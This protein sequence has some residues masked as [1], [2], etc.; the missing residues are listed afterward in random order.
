MVTAACVALAA[1]LL[2]LPPR[3]G[4]G[5]LGA[6]WPVRGTSRS[7]RAPGAAVAV[8]AGGVLGLLVAGP[9]GALSGMLVAATVRR[10]RGARRTEAA[11]TGTA[12]ELAAAVSRMADEL[13]AGA[14]PAAALGGCTADGPQARDVLASAAT[15]SRL[16]DDVPHALRRGADRHPEVRAEIERL[17]AAWTLSDRHGVPLA[18][19][20]AGAR[21]D[22]VWRVQF[23]AR[24]RAELAGPRATALVLTGLP[25]LGLALGQLVGA[26]PVGVLRGGLLGQALLVTGVA[27][28]VTGV[29][30]SEQILRAAVPR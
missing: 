29:A 7:W 12:G 8:L 3:A 5:R 23:A 26:D 30:W 10:T 11:A 27:L 4:V 18:E 16:G 14:H 13:A 1:A 24:V 17:A 6:L 22:L 28:A 21:A 25:G 20:L 19:L 15:A 9:A 2:V